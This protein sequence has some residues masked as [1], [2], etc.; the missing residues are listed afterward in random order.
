MLTLI[1]HPLRRILDWFEGLF[2]K[3]FGPA[4]NPLRQPG[5]LSFFFFWVSAVTGIYVFIVFDTSI[6]GAF[7]SVE[8]ITQQWYL[9]GIMRSLHRYASDAMVATAALHLVRE[10]SLDRY[11][12][13]RWFSWFT[14]VPVI[15]LL[16][17]SGIS[18]Y[19]L[20]WDELAQYVAIGSMEWIDW[21]SIFGEPV[22]NNFLTRDS[23]DDRFFSLL[24]FIHIFG[25]LFLLFMM[26]IHI[27]RINSSRTNPPRGLAIGSFV[28]LVA[29]SFAYPA[30]SHP[31]ADLGH[32]PTVLN[33]DWFFMFLYPAFD[34]WGPGALWGIAFGGSLAICVLPW[35]PPMKRPVPA[36][37]HLEQCNGCTRCF[38]DCPYSAV[39]M[40]PRTDGRPFEKEAV[41]NPDLCV[42]CGI[43][44][45]ACPMSTPFRQSGNLVTGIDF[46]E[47]SL[48]SLQTRMGE[49][50]DRARAGQALNHPAILVIGC[51]HGA[52][53][54]AI[55]TGNVASLSLP[56]IGMLPPSFLD[57]AL[58]KQGVDGVVLT[59]C[60]DGDCYHRFG[61]QW[62]EDRMAGLRD[63]YLRK[64]VPRERLHACWA[65]KTGGDRLSREVE[66]FTNLLTRINDQAEMEDV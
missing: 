12:G 22:A 30:V 56:C 20:V 3:P 4:W 60:G 42:S 66:E 43:C 5:T 64:R 19:W 47:P 6:A 41:V 11:R 2:D 50:I 14:G 25:P 27:L 35:L 31:P 33:L 18:G 9:G 57:F 1:Q 17:V 54:E 61:I 28:M 32:V 46:K 29:L 7:S 13:V 23:L 53:V 38:E 36:E 52:D 26:W 62:T 48:D 59:G 16:F 8:A 39:T 37:V 63:P 34:A 21:L 15:W 10:F 51:D 65:G 40:R 55:T 49:A 58:S 45:G 44:V 24:V